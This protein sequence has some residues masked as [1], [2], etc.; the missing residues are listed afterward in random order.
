MKVLV[1]IDDLLVGGT[2]RNLVEIVSA[3]RDLVDWEILALS[4][5]DS[6]LVGELRKASIHVEQ[7]DIKMHG[8][9]MT[10]RSV[11]GFARGARPD[12]VL[13]LRDVSKALLPFFLR[14]CGFKILVMR[15]ENPLFFKTLS[16][17]SLHLLQMLL[18]GA[19][20]CVCAGFMRDEF[21]KA[22]PFQ[23][24]REMRTIPNCVADS[25]FSVQPRSWMSD[26]ML[27]IVSVGNLRREKN[28]F[29]QIRIAEEL[30]RRGLR[31]SVNI[32][33]EGPLRKNIEEAI[34]DSG[35]N[36]CFRLLGKREDVAPLFAEADVFLFTSTSEGFGVAVLEAMAS[37]LPVVAYDLPSLREIDDGKGFITLVPQGDFKAAAAKITELSLDPARMISIGEKS[38]DHVRERYSASAVA[39]QW[40][41]YFRGIL[42]KNKMES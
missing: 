37:G 27:R 13:F 21:R 18:S 22:F 30:R 31:F 4:E 42:A 38:R 11:V 15:W 14:S 23:S 17:Y 16:M 36:D 6:F 40:L 34:S 29:E 33:G 12:V 8:V 25:F 32:A 2:E 3:S 7:I 10:L 39:G 35:L 41:E 19:G 28:H 26:G 20:Q 9:A 5:A 1:I 24:G